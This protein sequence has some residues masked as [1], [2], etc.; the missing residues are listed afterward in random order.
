MFRNSGSAGVEADTGEGRGSHLGQGQ[1]GL[2]CL[3]LVRVMVSW[4][5]GGEPQ[6]SP[7][8]LCESNSEL[9]IAQALQI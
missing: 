6:L 4:Q 3:R 5:L 8:T 1:Q 9:T 2:A 7:V